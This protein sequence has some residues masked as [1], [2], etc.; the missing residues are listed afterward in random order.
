MNTDFGEI[1]KT[2]RKR[3]RLS[4]TEA[5]VRL[6]ISRVY[7]SQIERG[8]SNN[9]S[10]RLGCR[11]LDLCVLT[12]NENTSDRVAV[13]LQALEASGLISNCVLAA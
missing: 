13:D 11:I 7:I 5:A 4:Q 10:W 12:T 1:L 9:I 2:Y 6:G 8:V 3:E